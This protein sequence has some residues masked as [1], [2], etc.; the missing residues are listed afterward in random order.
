MGLIVDIVPN[1]MA[2]ASGNAWW[3]D[4]LA[5][6]RDSRYARY[7]DIDWEPDDPHLRGK[8]LLPI[9]G[10]PYEE[11]LAAGEIALR[12]D[13]AGNAFIQ[14]FDH[15][16]PLAAGALTLCEQA[17]SAA[18]DPASSA[19]RDASAPAARR[20]ALSSGLVADRRMTKSIGAASSTSTSLSPSA[21]RM[22]K[23]SRPFTPRC[24]AFT[25]R[26]SSTA[27]ASTT[28]TASHGRRTTAPSCG[29]ACARSSASG[30]STAPPGP[31][32]SLSKRSSP[33]MKSCRK[34]GERMG[35]PATISWT[36]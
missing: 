5:R 28:S 11:A 36:R 35:L 13:N 29:R 17:S 30:R 22:T 31:P 8:V 4:V 24:S 26:G 27:C 18:F 33:M 14:Y 6:G 15:K 21:W 20:A 16:F 7:F 9:L 12:G 1:H 2:A 10:R 3:M 25:Q 19:G 34:A 32:I 23:C